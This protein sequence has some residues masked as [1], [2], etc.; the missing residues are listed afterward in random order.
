MKILAIGNS[1]SQDAT[2]YIEDMAASAGVTDIIAANLY[3]GG[4]PL[5]HHAENL[6]TN[7]PDYDYERHAKGL[8]KTSIRDALRSDKWD[9]ITVQ[10]VSS[11][12]GFYETYHPHLEIV[13][14][15]VKA[16][17]PDAR[18]YFHRTWAYEEGSGHGAFP[19]YNRD[20]V[21]M[22]NAIEAV[23]QRLSKEYGLSII[24]SGNVITALKKLPEFDITAGGIS[25]YRDAFHM[26]YS[27]G[28]YAAAATWLKTLCNFDLNKVSFLPEGANAE[29]AEIVKRTVETV[30]KKD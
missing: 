18:I 19:R 30:C 22:D 14:R 8:Y 21:T 1:F 25:L 2:A 5:S 15:E 4:C 23:Y 13:L 11:D 29:L 16:E 9:I 28:R 12:S 24:P 17:C 10:Q 20:R 27:Y 6:G 3:I 7:T 26:S